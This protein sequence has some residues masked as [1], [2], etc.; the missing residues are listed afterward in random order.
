M[1]KTI[2]DYMK[3]STLF[4]LHVSIYRDLITYFSFKK[5]ALLWRANNQHNKTIYIGSDAL[6]NVKVGNFS[7]GRLNVLSWR[8]DGEHLDIGNY[9]S[10]ADNVT[11]ILGGNHNING[12]TTFPM[13]SHKNNII[14]PDDARTK[15]PIVI[16]DDVWIGFGA[17][18]LSGV[19]IGKGSIIAAGTVVTKSF[20][21]YS[22]I[23]GNPAKLIRK[24]LKD[25]QIKSCSNI[26]FDT[27]N[28]NA[29]IND[30][31]DVFYN[32]P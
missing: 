30:D 19:K 18:I 20:P 26:S 32:V 12:F 28:L 10:I 8:V 13:R 5:R 23:G 14:H 15:G 29:I 16:E 25:E 4:M 9:V 31:I 2:K 7:Y 17:I 27:L 24:R 6:K 21:P 3:K 11:F 1:I 22:I